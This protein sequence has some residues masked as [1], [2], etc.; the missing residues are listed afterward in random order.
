MPS[1]VLC[2]FSES[3]ISNFG[4]SLVEEDVGYFEISVD[5]VLLWEISESLE[6]ISDDRFCPVLVHPSLFPQARLQISLIAEF[7]DYIAVSVACED[8][9][10]S[11]DIGVIQLFEYIDLWEE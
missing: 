10:A 4:L 9:E 11:E 5:D 6:D 2:K 8:F 3:E 7:R 1:K